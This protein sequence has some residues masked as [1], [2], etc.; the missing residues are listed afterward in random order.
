MGPAALK[1]GEPVS[2]GST[3]RYGRANL[4]HSSLSGSTNRGPWLRN[5]P[6]VSHWP[7]LTQ[8]KIVRVDI[9]CHG[10]SLDQGDGS[11]TS[12]VPANVD[13]AGAP[14]AGASSPTRAKSREMVIALRVALEGS[15]LPLALSPRALCAKWPWCRWRLLG[16]HEVKRVG[17]QTKSP[18]RIL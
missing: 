6:S 18:D 9:H 13:R 8:R 15:E 7:A 10:Q 5:C 17:I 2:L 16:M 1:L 3:A 4:L 12:A 14:T 11:G